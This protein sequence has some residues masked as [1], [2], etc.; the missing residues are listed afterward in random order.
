MRFYIR[1]S[2]VF[3]RSA[4]CV[5]ARHPELAR[6]RG[7]VVRHAPPSRALTV[8]FQISGYI[9]PRISPC[10]AQYVESG[11]SPTDSTQT[12]APCK[13]IMTGR[14]GIALVP[15]ADDGAARPAGIAPGEGAEEG[16]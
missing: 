3:A 9:I 7:A 4:Q 10:R 8:N 11:E 12:H 15:T 2:P 1:Y 14:P 5:V 6:T 16:G 13:K